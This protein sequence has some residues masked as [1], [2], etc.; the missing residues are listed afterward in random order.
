MGKCIWDKAWIG[1]CGKDAITNKKL[2]G[3]HVGQKC[4][5]CGAE[6]VRDCDHTGIQ[7]VCGA[8]LCGNCVHGMSPKGKP[9]FL[10]LGGGHVTK[11]VYE[12]QLAEPS[13]WMVLV[14]LGGLVIW[15][16]CTRGHGGLGKRNL[17]SA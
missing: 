15:R 17:R 16:T 2:C 11:K 8:P 6:A 13:T 9:G 14:G 3:E 10:N 7:F 4:A 12:K 5:S 1:V